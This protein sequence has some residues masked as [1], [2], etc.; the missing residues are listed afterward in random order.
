MSRYSGADIAAACVCIGVLA[1]FLLVL[2][3]RCVHR[4]RKWPRYG[5]QGRPQRRRRR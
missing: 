4:E 2:V 1:T 5:L 3:V